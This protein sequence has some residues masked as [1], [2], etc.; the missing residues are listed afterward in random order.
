MAPIA[1]P[2]LHPG[3]LTHC[4]G[5]QSTVYRDRQLIE[6]EPSP[7]FFFCNLYVLIVLQTLPLDGFGGVWFVCLF[8]FG[9]RGESLIPEGTI[10]CPVD[11]SAYLQQDRTCTLALHCCLQITP[12][13]CHSYQHTLTSQEELSQGQEFRQALL[14][15]A[16]SLPGLQPGVGQGLKAHLKAP[17]G[18]GL[19]LHGLPCCW[20]DLFSSGLL[21]RG[22]WFFRPAGFNSA[23][24][25]GNFLPFQP[26]G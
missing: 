25:L 26:S 9:L 16:Q 11:F 6:T 7:F 2:Q 13:F 22:S 4:L 17:W 1:I 20:Q 15:P 24:H 21:D 12:N 10:P 8:N 19:P 3:A 5:Y 14:A 23:P 18:K